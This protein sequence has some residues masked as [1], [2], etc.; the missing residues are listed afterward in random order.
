MAENKT[1]LIKQDSLKGVANAI[2]EKTNKTDLIPFNDF[3]D[4]IKGIESG[5]SYE[6]VE[7]ALED[8]GDKDSIYFYKAYNSEWANVDSVESFLE[9]KSQSE[10]YHNTN[11][12]W[13]AN[14]P[15]LE[16]CLEHA[17]ETNKI[18]Y[19]SENYGE[20][21]ADDKYGSSDELIQKVLDTSYIYIPD[22]NGEWGKAS[23]LDDIFNYNPDI[24]D[25]SYIWYNNGSWNSFYNSSVEDY[26][27]N[28]PYSLDDIISGLE[29]MGY[30]VTNE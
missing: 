18:Y 1:L 15:Y 27:Q 23:S 28:G 16:E 24:C 22:S 9:E 13:E 12:Y 26:I 6:T 4:E 25:T 10:I 20:W 17:G 29:N 11:G 2:R 21:Q 3:A 14:W 7:Q 30:V 19:Y 8:L 5:S